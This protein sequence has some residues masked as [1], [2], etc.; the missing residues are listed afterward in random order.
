[1][2]ELT[3]D[4]DFN[5]LLV[6][7]V[8][9]ALVDTMGESV[10]RAVKACLEIS[11]ITSDPKGFSAQLQKFSGGTNLIERKIMR[12]LAAMIDERKGGSAVTEGRDLRQ[13]I[14]SCRGQFNLR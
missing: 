10:S 4:G 3:G 5:K 1:M 12:N 7:A 8:D 11:T 14:E 13:F 2:I 6:T 9:R